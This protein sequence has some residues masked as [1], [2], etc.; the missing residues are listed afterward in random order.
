MTAVTYQEALPGLI[1]AS[2]VAAAVALGLVVVVLRQR[3][4]GKAPRAEGDAEEARD[5]QA[6]ELAA[7]TE[8][9]ERLAERVERDLSQQMREARDLLAE[10]ERRASEPRE[11]SSGGSPGRYEPGAEPRRAEVIRLS[12]QGVDA[13]EIARRMDL[14]VGEVELMVHLQGSSKRG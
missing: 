11:G 1:A 2:F 4:R 5:G 3:T 6:R 7:L 9:L 8:R 14:E 13:V 10:T 12:R